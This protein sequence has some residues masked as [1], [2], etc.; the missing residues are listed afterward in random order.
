[1][2]HADRV[3][4]V[5]TGTA[6]TIRV[7]LGSVVPGYRSF[8]SATQG[9]E[10][11]YL[12]ENGTDWEFGMGWTDAVN[13]D[14]E[15]APEFL[16]N[17][18]FLSSNGGAL[19]TSVTGARITLVNPAASALSIYPDVDSPT[20]LIGA[21][22][23][24]GGSLAGGAGAYAAGVRAM[25]F[26][27]YAVANGNGLI[28]LGAKT[29]ANIAGAL[30]IGDGKSTAQRGHAHEWVGSG[31]SADATAGT[32]SHDTGDYIPNTD[33]AQLVQIQVKEYNYWVAIFF[34]NSL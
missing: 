30:T 26:G 2:I 9:E 11:I 32:I 33:S 8:W 31:S 7:V 28:A 4:Q 24:G 22:A 3:A 14:P 17:D 16:R 6:S 5:I 12:I 13:V 21:N 1:M 18:V 27:S 23:V 15:D 34:M 10:C 25:A 19:I 20:A 29:V